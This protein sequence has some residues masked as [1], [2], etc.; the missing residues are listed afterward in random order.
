MDPVRNPR[1]RRDISA[2][3][4]L[5][6]DRVDVR[7][8]SLTGL[9]ILASI[10]T[11]YVARSFLLPIVLAVLLSFLLAPVIRILKRI[12]VPEAVG[13]ALVMLTLVGGVLWSA[14]TLATP[15]AAWISSAPETLRKVDDKVR[16]L[17]KPVQQMNQAAE[18]VQEM[19]TVTTG[20]SD[21]KVQKVEIKESGITES[22]FSQTQGFLAGGAVMVI[23]LYFLLASGDLFLRKLVRV[24]PRLEDKRVAVDIARQIE[25]Q[26]SRYL[27][28]VTCINIALGTIMAIL[29]S[30]IG[31][32]NP[33]LWGVMI[34][35]FNFVPYVGPL[36]SM[37]VLAL[38]GIT[39]FDSLG[40]ALLAPGLY[41]CVE[42]I[43]GNVVT[44]ALLG[45]RLSL[46]PV[47]I[48]VGVTFWG[49]L[50][51]IGGALLAVPMLATLKILCDEIEP[52]AAIGEFL[53]P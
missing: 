33:V 35:T 38:V 14:Y 18:K 48:F 11:M 5:F 40:Y 6:D 52:L 16:A 12:H 30:L 47:V 26:I 20:G 39:S 2:L 8:V 43:E 53:G 1:P 36:A 34:G 32:P 41:F 25:G 19:A 31:M 37:T 15:A 27:L 44:P 49:W 22:L 46:N 24:L 29:L 28:T 21:A 13:A 51:G 7:S 42:V 3:G 23:L 17:R 9:F 4:A 45:R 50:W 10:Y